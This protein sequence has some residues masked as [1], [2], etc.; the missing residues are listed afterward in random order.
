M[1]KNAQ[2]DKACLS[3]LSLYWQIRETFHKQLNT[4][5]KYLWKIFVI[6]IRA[7]KLMIQIIQSNFTWNYK[8]SGVSTYSA[9]KFDVKSCSLSLFISKNCFQICTD[10]K[11]IGND[12]LKYN[13]SMT[14]PVN[15]TNT[16]SF[17]SSWARIFT[18]SQAPLV[19]STGSVFP[20]NYKNQIFK[21]G[22]Q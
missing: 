11:S 9:N 12:F 2:V 20:W 3:S 15:A 10:C 8:Q 18:T 17:L 1:N 19:N 5:V 16:I 14:A 13:I 7:I 22:V 6:C 21:F 4:C